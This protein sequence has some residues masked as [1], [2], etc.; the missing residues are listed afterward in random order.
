MDDNFNFSKKADHF[1]IAEFINGSKIISKVL[2]ELY[3]PKVETDEII[4]ICKLDEK[5]YIQFLNEFEFR[6]NG[7]DE[8][9]DGGINNKFYIKKAFCLKKPSIIY[10]SKLREFKVLLQ[11]Y[12][13]TIVSEKNNIQ[14]KGETKGIFTIFN[15]FEIPPAKT[16]IRKPNGEATIESP[17]KYEFVLASNLKLT[18]DTYYDHEYQEDNII[19]RPYTVAEFETDLDPESINELI[20]DVDD[21]LLILSLAI[22]KICICTG[23]AASSNNKI[24]RYYR[25]DRVIPE[26]ADKY[27]FLDSLIEQFDL[28]SFL[29]E[30]YK[31]FIDFNDKKLLRNIIYPLLLKNKPN[32]ETRYLILFAALESL[33]LNYKKVNGYE[34]ILPNNIFKIFKKE[35]ENNIKEKRDIINAKLQLS[36]E[37]IEEK[38]NFICSKTS[39]LNR[40]PFEASFNLF[41]KYYKV[42]IDDLWP[43]VNSNKGASLSKIRNMLIHGEIFSNPQLQATV[44]AKTHLQVI[45]ER[46]VLAILG[47]DITKTRVSPVYLS[48]QFPDDKKKVKYFQK[49]LAEKRIE[50]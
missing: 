21:F 6:V 38:L 11:A 16:I 12:D 23:W 14:E 43:L 22:G 35:L 28:K 50:N 32:V 10:T 15:N 37:I 41:N 7:Y 19:S 13:L 40:I 26:K 47:W 49:L 9:S 39:E 30:G 20:V 5:K 34:S 45:I 4:L 25:R 1:I 36:D 17:E 44:L 33:L 24:V 29:K 18:F 2:T 46:I 3:L 42:Y 31:S 8:F 48:K 27:S